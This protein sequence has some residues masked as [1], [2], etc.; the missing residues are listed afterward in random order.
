MMSESVVLAAAALVLGAI[1]GSFINALSFRFGTGVS[2][3]TGRSRCMQCNHTLGATDLVPVASYIWLRG[4]CHYC[5]SS[6]S[7]Q[8]P[9]VEVVAAGLSLGV[10]LL[11]P[12]LPW[13]AFWLLVWLIILFIVVYDARHFIIP[14]SCSLLLLV[15]SFAYLVIAVYQGVSIVGDW[16]LFASGPL[17]ALPLFLLSLISSGRWMGWAD[18]VFELSLAWLLGLSA[19]GT[20]LIL[21]VWLGAA[22]GLASIAYTHLR[23]RAGVSGRTMSMQSEIPFAP[24]LA[25]GAALVYFFHVDFFSNL[26]LLF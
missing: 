13:Y 26:A 15:L 12:G 3:F 20:A 8:Y 11:N 24:F 5:G 22:G 23:G 7:L 2:I 16:P 14:W 19:G 4:R 9:L 10:C 21:A 6:V 17:L 25:L 18:G 1:F